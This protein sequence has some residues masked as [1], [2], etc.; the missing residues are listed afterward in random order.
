MTTITATA[1]SVACDAGF[2]A[3]NATYAKPSVRLDWKAAFDS[4][5]SLEDAASAYK[6][7]VAEGI[8]RTEPSHLDKIE[9]KFLSAGYQRGF[10]LGYAMFR[11]ITDGTAALA[12]SLPI[13]WTDI[14]EAAQA[15]DVDAAFN[16][17][18]EV[19]QSVKAQRK[20]DRDAAEVDLLTQAQPF[21]N[22]MAF[23]AGKTL[24]DSERKALVNARSLINGLLA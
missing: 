11:G 1:L 8:A 14:A 5:V 19:G 16:A 10:Y 18:I 3:G 23:N 22:A 6:A 2:N 4:G 20:N 13:D 7:R 12:A 21:V 9:K 15:D 17:I 24:T